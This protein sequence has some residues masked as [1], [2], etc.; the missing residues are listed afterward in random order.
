M[1]GIMTEHK[2]WESLLPNLFCKGCD[3]VPFTPWTPEHEK[4]MSR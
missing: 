2:P 4:E 1:L 3:T